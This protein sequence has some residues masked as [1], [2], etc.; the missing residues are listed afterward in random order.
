MNV[1]FKA[2]K[3]IRSVDSTTGVWGKTM[4]WLTSLEKL[5]TAIVWGVF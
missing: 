2:E 4:L 1:R 3:E 5:S